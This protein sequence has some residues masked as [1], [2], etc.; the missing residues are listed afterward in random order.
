[1][2]TGLPVDADSHASWHDRCLI[3]G[4]SSLGA[5][6]GYEREHLVRCRACG[7]VF[8]ARM[9]TDAEL[10]ARYRDYGHA[11]RDYPITRRRYAAILNT[12]EPSRVENRLL[13]FGCGAG[14]FLEEARNRGWEVHGTE[15]SEFALELA[16]SKQLNVVP[17][18]IDWGTYAPGSFDVVTAF[19]VFEHV[20]DPMAEAEGIA[21]V[22]RDGGTLYLTTPNFDALSRRLLGPRWS[23][24]AYPE[25]LSYFSPRTIRSWLGRFGFIAES[26]T[27]TGVSVAQLRDIRGARCG[28][29][30]YAATDEQLRE[31]IEDS[32]LL[33]LAKAAANTAL[34]GLGAGDTLKAWFRLAAA[35]GRPAWRAA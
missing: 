1:M 11:W 6:T 20:R 3:C 32:R 8:S 16:R 18:P 30:S 33:Q 22:L 23:V 13:D 35:P 17:A 2:A 14:Y 29:T 15:Y 10:T 12:L 26:V 9:P 7:M 4:G 27:S 28:G 25:H 5:L 21:H 31:T 24:I 19:E 34:S